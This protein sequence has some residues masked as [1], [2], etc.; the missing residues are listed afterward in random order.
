M[1]F[2]LEDKRL[3]RKKLQTK[4][5]QAKKERK[6]SLPGTHRHSQDFSKGGGGV[7]L[8][9]IEGTHQIVM[10]TNNKVSKKG[11]FNYGQEIVMAFSPPVVGCLVKKGLQKERVR[12]TPGPPWLCPWD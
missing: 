9:N 6:V 8:C 10:S 4:L 5:Q 2:T 12:G 7:T 3:L 11:L 1:L